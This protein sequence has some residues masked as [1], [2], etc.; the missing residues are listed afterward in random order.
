VQGL[1]QRAVDVVAAVDL[2]RR[3]EAGQGGAGLH[4]LGDG[5][6]VPALGAEGDGVATV[7]I[8]RHQHQ[9]VLEFAEVIGPTLHGEDLG[10]GLAEAVA[11]EQAGGQHA[12]QALDG[13]EHRAAFQQHLAGGVGQ[14]AGQQ[15]QPLAELGPGR[16]SA[17]FSMK[18]A[19]SWRGVMPL[20]RPAAMKPPA[21]TPM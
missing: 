16:A 4:G 13:A 2:D 18:A 21:L 5:H 17:V 11:A 9:A 20:A 12:A 15:A 6:M 8:G 14:Q 3:E 1:L 7:Q 10:Q 19:Q